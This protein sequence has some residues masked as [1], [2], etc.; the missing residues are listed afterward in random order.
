MANSFRTSDGVTNNSYHVLG[1]IGSSDDSITIF[2]RGRKEWEN[3]GCEHG[4]ERVRDNTIQRPKRRH[5][6]EKG[7]CVKQS[8][9]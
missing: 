3:E 6:E 9:G 4:S 1:S 5:R 2:W 7:G 8:G